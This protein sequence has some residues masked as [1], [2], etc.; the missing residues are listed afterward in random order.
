MESKSVRGDRDSEARWP[1]EPSYGTVGASLDSRPPSRFVGVENAPGFSHGHEKA[2]SGT[3]TPAPAPAV[4]RLAE[5]RAASS[6]SSGAA[7]YTCAPLGHAV[8]VRLIGETGP[9]GTAAA[10]AAAVL[11]R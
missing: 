9:F 5:S 11:E 1:V 6:S 3:T 2:E 8:E 7:G 4:P 10:A